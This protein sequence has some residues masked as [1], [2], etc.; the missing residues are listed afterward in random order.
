MVASIWK[1]PGDLLVFLYFVS[2]IPIT[3]F[4]DS[5]VLLRNYFQYPKLLT[6]VCDNYVR[7]F[8]DKLVANP[9]LFFQVFTACEL[10][11]QFPFFFFAAYA[12][13]YGSFTLVTY[14]DLCRK[15][16]DQNPSYCLRS[17]RGH[18]VTT[19]LGC[20]VPRS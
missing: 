15:E 13:Y 4:I 12:Y 20:S 14:T 5:Q 17:S 11:I 6:D 1:R 9:P 8:Q 10:I 19:H 7:D 2:H 3:I 18:N 16:L